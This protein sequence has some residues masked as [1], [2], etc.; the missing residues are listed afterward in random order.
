MSLQSGF[1]QDF[2]LHGAVSFDPALW[3]QCPEFVSYDSKAGEKRN[4]H[5]QVGQLSTLDEFSLVWVLG[6]PR[7]NTL[8]KPYGKKTLT[9]NSAPVFSATL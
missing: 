2:E 7:T 1:L 4:S 3:F 6:S 8:A 5:S 9:Q